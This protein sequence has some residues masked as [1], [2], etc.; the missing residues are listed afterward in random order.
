[1][2]SVSRVDP[3]T[4]T[5]THT[6]TLPNRGHGSGVFDVG[7][8]RIAVG[9]GAAWA[10]DPDGTVARIDP[11]S[12]RVVKNIKASAGML[13][14]GAEGVWVLSDQ[15]VA[16]I[17]PAR[18]RLGTPIPLPFGNARDIAVGGGAVW[19]TDDPQGLL[20]RID[21]GRSRTARDVDVGVGA[22]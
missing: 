5:I 21:V 17:D 1:M 11:R 3:K 18:N 22:F 6:A 2:V 4:L 14:T 12:G 15:G 20:W 16:R 19:V 7:R 10:I 8:S 9:D 13:A